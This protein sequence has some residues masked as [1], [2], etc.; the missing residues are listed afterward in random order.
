MNLY[1]KGLALDILLASFELTHVSGVQSE[2]ERNDLGLNYFFLTLMR[3]VTDY[4]YMHMVI[5][6]IYASKTTQQLANEFRG[7]QS[8]LRWYVPI[9][10]MRLLGLTTILHPVYVTLL[11]LRYEE[12]RGAMSL[13]GLLASLL[14]WSTYLFHINHWV[15][16]LV[17]R[18]L[19]VYGWYAIYR[20][21]MKA[22]KPKLID[23]LPSSLLDYKLAGTEDG[24]LALVPY[25]AQVGDKIALLKGAKCPF[26]VRLWGAKW[27]LVGD[28]YLYGVMDGE[29]WNEEECLGM[30]FI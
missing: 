27:K 9:A 18:S 10:L 5:T 16:D 24:K 23:M 8:S 21:L 26:V 2:R 29:A 28:A 14:F 4:E 12:Y 6:D 25:N 1:R 13:K 3:G 22:P 15:V 20:P 30:A 7:F 11:G 19:G 17:S